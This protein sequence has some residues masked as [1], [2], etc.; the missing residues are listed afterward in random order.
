[1]PI[2][3]YKCGDCHRA[4]EVSR[5]MADAAARDVKCPSC[6]SQQAERVYSS[7]F[8]KTSKKS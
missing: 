4:F 6:G 1:M 5:S 7:V 2:Y 3:E 8:T